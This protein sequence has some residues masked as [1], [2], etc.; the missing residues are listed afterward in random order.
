MAVGELRAGPA[1]GVCGAQASSLGLCGG[2]A[3]QSIDDGGVGIGFE[4]LGLQYHDVA[5]PIPQQ[6]A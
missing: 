6:H 4:Q 5:H 3:K 1:F 2:L